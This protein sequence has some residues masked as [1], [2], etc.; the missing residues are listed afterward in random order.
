LGGPILSKEL[1]P[2]QWTSRQEVDPPLSL[3]NPQ[4]RQTIPEVGCLFYATANETTKG[5]RR[6]KQVNRCRGTRKRH[7]VL[8]ENG[9]PRNGGVP[10]APNISEKVNFQNGDSSRGSEYA[11]L[12]TIQA[13]FLVLGAG[14][15]NPV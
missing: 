14:K 15:R 1:R 11:R 9:S 3:L 7:L 5:K 2:L 12:Q 6:V 8:G 13:Q 4:K 10:L